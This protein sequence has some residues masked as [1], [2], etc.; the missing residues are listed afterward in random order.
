MKHLGKACDEWVAEQFKESTYYK[1][2]CGKQSFTTTA[3]CVASKLVRFGKHI[4]EEGMELIL[5]ESIYDDLSFDDI[6][7][8][9]EDKR[10][11]IDGCGL[12]PNNEHTMFIDTTI[13]EQ[14]ITFPIASN[15]DG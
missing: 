14:N 10:D 7:K 11:G 1:Y 13:Q 8:S 3:L 5:N 6:R 2:Y 15:N 9:R 12:K 4:K